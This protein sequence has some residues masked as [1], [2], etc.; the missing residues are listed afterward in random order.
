MQNE[1]KR[2]KKDAKTNSK[3]AR[4]SETKR[5]KVRMLQFCLHVPLKTVLTHKKTCEKFAS[6]ASKRNMRNWQTFRMF[7][8]GLELFYMVHVS[9][10]VEFSL[11]F[12]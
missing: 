7:L 5:N 3:L 11:Y 12:A 9:E 8:Y 1:A 2:S 6:F 4:L 10:T